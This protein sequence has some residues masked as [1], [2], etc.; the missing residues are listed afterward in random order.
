MLQYGSQI[1]P[2]VH[3]QN[4][5]LI[6]AI[7]CGISILLL[8]NR[9]AFLQQIQWI[10]SPFLFLSISNPRRFTQG[11]SPIGGNFSDSQ[12]SLLSLFSI[13]FSSAFRKGL[14]FLGWM[15]FR[16]IFTFTTVRFSQIQF[17]F[18]QKHANRQTIFDRGM[19][20]MFKRSQHMLQ[21]VEFI[22]QPRQIG[23]FNQKFQ[24]RPHLT[25]GR[26]SP[27]NVALRGGYQA[28][29]PGNDK[30]ILW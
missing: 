19:V 27:F 2:N 10:D 20:L 26:Q 1:R 7:D 15:E 11:F 24:F 5:V 17:L 21:G 23:T 13:D 9:N 12:G 29:I 22:V 8:Q 16:T 25:S 28:A 6:V 3:G 14:T 4:V 30:D 18:L